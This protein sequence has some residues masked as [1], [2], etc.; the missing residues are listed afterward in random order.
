MKK[1]LFSIVTI[2]LLSL[3][4]I[5]TCNAQLL[6]QDGAVG[7][8]FIDFNAKKVDI[9]DAKNDGVETTLGEY[10]AQGKPLIVDFWASWCGPCRRE[11][12]NF[13]SVYAPE[14]AGKVNFLGVAV[15]EESVENTKEAMAALPISWPVIIAGDSQAGP[16]KQYGI[17]G[18]PHIML[19]GK[20]GIIKARNIRGEAIKE[21][22]EAEL[23]K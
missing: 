1:T 15:W 19:I 10:V 5:F 23:K 18:I 9:K 12:Q 4:S 6:I 8:K 17:K 7:S 20:D 2:A 16:T 13:L 22:I 14:Y 3:S 21:A 11:I